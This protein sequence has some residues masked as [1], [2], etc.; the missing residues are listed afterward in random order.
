MR[1]S[2]D[3]DAF[4]QVL[5]AALGSRAPVFSL[6]RLG[7]GARA[8]ADLEPAVLDRPTLVGGGSL[9]NPTNPAPTPHAIDELVRRAEELGV[10]QI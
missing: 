5:C 6:A 8:F 4:E 3:I 10:S 2:A 9:H 7:Q 1:R